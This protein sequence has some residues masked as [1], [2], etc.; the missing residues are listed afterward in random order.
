MTH[1]WAMGLSAIAAW[2]SAIIVMFA[3]YANGIR[4]RS[5]RVRTWAKAMSLGGLTLFGGWLV[6]YGILR[7]P[8]LL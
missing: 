5:G 6:L 4:L 8:A 3:V 7:L 1:S 2:L